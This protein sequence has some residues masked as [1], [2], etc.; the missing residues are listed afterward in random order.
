VL[1]SGQAEAHEFAA[2]FLMPRN[3]IIHG[4][5]QRPDWDRLL[6]LRDKWH[7]SLAALLKRASTLETFP[8]E[9]YTQAMKTMSARRWRG[10]PFGDVSGKDVAGVGFVRGRVDRC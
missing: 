10:R 3:D 5:P 1:D 6:A 7:V 9:L 8:P 4:L 2:A